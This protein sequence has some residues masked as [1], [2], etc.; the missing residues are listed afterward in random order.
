MVDKINQVDEVAT[1]AYS[2]SRRQAP[3]EILA[4]YQESMLTQAKGIAENSEN[5]KNPEALTESS[6]QLADQS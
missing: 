6:I 5:A 1:N 4:N 2:R 3:D